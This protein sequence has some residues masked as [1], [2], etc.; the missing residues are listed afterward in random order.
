MP[1]ISCTCALFVQ[2]A[3]IKHRDVTPSLRYFTAPDV[4]VHK[5]YTFVRLK[6]ITL[7]ILQSS[8]GSSCQSG[9]LCLASFSGILIP[10]KCTT[11]LN[12]GS[13]NSAGLWQHPV[14]GDYDTTTGV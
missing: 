12:I 8:V 10:P 6:A 14:L 13:V 7:Q 9:T 4:F 3:L 1:R 5:V 2:H 11:D